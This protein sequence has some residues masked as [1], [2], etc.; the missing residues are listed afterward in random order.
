MAGEK[1]T[2]PELRH[3][4]PICFS[5]H[6]ASKSRRRVVIRPA[7][8]TTKS[9]ESLNPELFLVHP[10]SVAARIKDK[11]CKTRG[12]SS[13]PHDDV[14]YLTVSNDDEGLPDVLE[15]KDATACYLKIS[16]VTLPAWKSHLDNHMDVI[17]KLRGE[18]DVMKDRERAREEE[19]KELREK[20]EVAMTEFEKNPT[21]VALQE[22]IFTLSTEVKKHKV[23]L[24][25]IMMKSRKWAGYHQSLL[26][27]ESKVTPLEA[28]KVSLKDIEVSLRKEVEEVKQDMRDVVSKFIPY[29][30]IELV[31]SDDMGSLIDRLVSSLI[32]YERCRVYEQVADMKDP[33]D[34]SKVKGYRSS[35][36]K[37]HTRASNDLATATF[38]WLDKFVVDPPAH[39]EALLSKKP[40]SL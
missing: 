21:V 16:A 17:E 10:G 12:G 23:S 35:Y 28:K 37:D 34:L 25:R 6:G 14:P 24:N 5:K 11:K 22:K 4:F 27:L 15:L 7:E 30:A 8:V 2:F 13:R 39:I 32:L 33:F 9:K 40:Q 36:K 29:G 19:C 3:W 1:G 31:H 20:C 18:F 38:P 26:T